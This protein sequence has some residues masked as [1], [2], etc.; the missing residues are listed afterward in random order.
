[1]DI[2]TYGFQAIP[3]TS[4][5]LKLS[6]KA[7]KVSQPCAVCSGK[8]KRSPNPP[9]SHHTTDSD[10]SGADIGTRYK[11]KTEPMIASTVNLTGCGLL[12]RT[13]LAYKEDLKGCEVLSQT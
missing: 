1:M 13:H 5:L 8:D 2:W 7:I 3:G 11:N 4:K 12:A 10:Q 9:A 6:K